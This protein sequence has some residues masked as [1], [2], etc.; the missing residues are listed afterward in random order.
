VATIPGTDVVVGR[1]HGDDRGE[2]LLLLGPE[3]SP[4][5]DLEDDKLEI[6]VTAFAWADAQVPDD[7]S[8]PELD[9]LWDLPLE[10]AAPPGLPDPVSAGEEIPPGYAS[11]PTSTAVVEFALGK[12]QSGTDPFVIS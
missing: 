9:P 8:V 1:A 2:F 6:R 4:F 11:T 12:L 10:L 3:A 5:G 7:P